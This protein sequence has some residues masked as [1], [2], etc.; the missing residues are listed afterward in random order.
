M[1]TYWS[2][3]KDMKASEYKLQSN[4]SKIENVL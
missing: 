4:A 3:L 1:E 2:I